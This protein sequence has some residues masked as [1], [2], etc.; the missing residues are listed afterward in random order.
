MKS[1]CQ[2][3]KE[4]RTQVGFLRAARSHMNPI[5]YC[6]KKRALMKKLSKALVNK[7]PCKDAI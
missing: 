3:I 5:M 1:K 4:L 2:E 7:V 6:M